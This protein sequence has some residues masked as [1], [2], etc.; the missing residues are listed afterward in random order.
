MVNFRARPRP[1]INPVPIEEKVQW[2]PEPVWTVLEKIKSL[3]H[4]QDSIPGPSRL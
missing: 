4:C 1:G 2:T 3:S